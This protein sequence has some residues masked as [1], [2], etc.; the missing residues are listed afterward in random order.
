LIAAGL[1]LQLG[2]I[3]DCADGQLA[4]L[5]H[6]ESQVGALLDFLFDEVK[7]LMVL[8]ASAARLWLVHGD[9]WYLV[10]GLVGVT[11][12]AS[13]MTLT[14]FMR[15]SEYLHA[16]GAPPL[17]PATERSS[18]APR[19]LHPLDLAEAA[20]R[21]VLHYPSWFLLV[22]VLDRLQIFLYLY[23]AAHLLHLGR[24]GLTVVRALGRR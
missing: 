10:V 3:I 8:A 19:S 22:C 18:F 4:R 7:A 5:K 6:L 17:M 12:A 9:P 13:G 14:T 20:G 21:L 24:A 11:A 1:L 16:V 2:Y 23:T 15:R